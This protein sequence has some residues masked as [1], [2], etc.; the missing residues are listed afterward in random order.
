MLVFLKKSRQLSLLFL[1]SAL[2]LLRMPQPLVTPRFFENEGPDF[3]G[4]A[5]H[6]SVWQALGHVYGG[7]LNLPCNVAV[8]LA[9]KLV[10]A[11][12]YP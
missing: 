1:F 2:L 8:L 7:Y 6:V 12:L 9:V 4:Y 3:F 5:W 10:R 11:G